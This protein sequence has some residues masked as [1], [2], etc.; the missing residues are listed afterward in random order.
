MNALKKIL[1]LYYIIFLLFLIPLTA[2]AGKSVA[3]RVIDAVS[4]KPVAGVNVFLART[5]LGCSSIDDGSFRIDGIP[6][7]TY[8]LV[9]QRIGYSMQIQRVQPMD[10]TELRVNAE[11]S[12]LALSGDAVHVVGSSPK[13]WTKN[14]KLFT[15]KFIGE[16]ENSGQCRI[17]NPEALDFSM[18]ER[19]GVFT[20][21]TDSVLRIEN[22]SLGYRIDAV[23]KSFSYADNQVAYILYPYFSELPNSDPEEA[24]R[25]ENARFQ[26]FR[27]SFRH[28]LS[29]LVRNRL[30]EEKFGLF[31]ADVRRHTIRLSPSGL[32]EVVSASVSGTSFDDIKLVHFSG[33][34]TATSGYRR[35]GTATV[36]MQTPA[37]YVDTLGNCYET[38]TLLVMGNWARERVADLLPMDYFPEGTAPDQTRPDYH[39]ALGKRALETEDAALARNRFRKA[40]EINPGC[41]EAMQGMASADEQDE[42]WGDAADWQ[43]RI[44]DLYPD[45]LEA[46]L[47]YAKDRREEGAHL[48]LLIQKRLWRDSEDHFRRILEI[49]STFEDVLFQY[50][51]LERYRGHHEAAVDLALR[52]LAIH[53]ND[54]KTRAGLFHLYDLLL[55]NRPSAEAES[56]LKSQSTVYGRY[57]LGEL[58]RR[59]GQFQKADSLFTAVPAEGG[60]FPA[61]PVLLSR[62]RLFVQQNELSKAEQAYRNAVGGIS[63]AFEAGFVRED[64]LPIANEEEARFLSDSSS[65]TMVSSY[66][67]GFWFKRNPMPSDSV[68]R[69]LIEHY[70]RLVYAEAN[71]RTRGISYSPRK[72][73][74][75]L[76][77]RLPEG[78]LDNRRFNDMGLAYIRHGKPDDEIWMPAGADVELNKF[79]EAKT[80]AP[81]AGAAQGESMQTQT[82]EYRSWLYRPMGEK[83][84]MILHFVKNGSEDWRLMSQFEKMMTLNEILERA[85]DAPLML[86]LA[87]NLRNNNQRNI[88]LSEL[89]KDAGVKWSGMIRTAYT[90]DRMTWSEKMKP[91]EAAAAVYR[92]RQTPK[93]DLFQLAYGIPVEKMRKQAGKK[94]SLVLE[95]GFEVVNDDLEQVVQ[96][97]HRF[98]LD[99]PTGVNVRNELFIDEFQF[100]APDAPLFLAFHARVAGTEILEG[101]RMPLAPSDPPRDRLAVSSLKPAFDIRPI[102][103]PSLRNRD[104]LA[105][106][107][108]PTNRARRGDPLYIYYEVYNLRPAGN[109]MTDYTVNFS[110]RQREGKKGLLERMAGLFG[111][112]GTYQISIRNNQSGT[113]RDVSDYMGFD[114]SK[115]APGQYELRLMVQDRNGKEEASSAVSLT[116]E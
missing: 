87:D 34:W 28:F 113:E 12:P 84:L 60:G 62:V 29:A 9:F 16:S 49:D 91:L 88:S 52:Q 5:M 109:G 53:P 101:W 14:L 44:L 46:N 37:V 93:T 65:W 82:A 3:G 24:L 18:D 31:V 36:R 27:G 98:V 55:C 6:N 70:R 21:S 92:F 74:E 63:N 72:R 111:G 39:V 71:Y 68:D 15:K 76:L 75:S 99:D 50:A 64:L 56:W 86:E 90:T 47:G 40:L 81:G 22:R 69:R 85:W 43:R 116:L 78:A 17:L 67:R 13:E 11:L 48:F 30:K 35:P 79:L 26:T 95:T 58:Y 2:T 100:E 104:A 108:N 66:V 94:D 10:S 83:P 77:V 105:M 19:T 32:H 23:L 25:R 54:E 1:S 97:H 107:T 73:N 89:P 59:K 106:T 57:F 7:G 115:A 112:D 96:G 45:H 114:V 42:K 80:G 4:R 20:A 51:L 38:A 8:D 102:G 110:L 61:Q 33:T 41:I 103:A